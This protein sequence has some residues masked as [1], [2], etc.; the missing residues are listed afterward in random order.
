MGNGRKVRIGWGTK[1][2][3]LM[4]LAAGALALP[5]WAMAQDNMGQGDTGQG[6][7]SQGGQDNGPAARAVRLS[8]VEGQVQLSQGNTVLAERALINTPLFEGTRI[9][10]SDDGRAEVQFED[11][12]VA[13]I[14]PDSSLTLGVLRQQGATS[15]TELDLVSGLGYF[16]LQGDTQS[17]HMRVQFGNSMVTASGF[18]VLRVNVDN[19]PGELAVFSGNAHLDGANSL[20]LDLHGGE[21]VRLSGTDP[22]NYA[23]AETIEPDSWDAWNSDRD[24]ALTSEESDRTA[25]TANV[26]NNNNPAWS[27]LDAN[28][29]WYNVPDQGYV[30]SP[31]EAE[32]SSWDPYGCGS[33]EWTPDYGYIWVSCESWGYM[34]YESGMWSYY[35]GFGWGWAPGSGNCWWDGGGWGYNI[36]NAPFQY[37]RPLRPRGGPVMPR[38]PIRPGGRYEPYPVISVNRLHNGNF[39]GSGRVRGAPIVVAGNTVQPLRPLA[40]RQDYGRESYGNLG[41][42]PVTYPVGNTY[43][44]TNPPAR[45]GYIQSPKSGEVGRPSYWPTAR[46]AG[47]MSRTNGVARPPAYYG[48]YSYH[49]PVSSRGYSPR[50][51]APSHGNFGRAPAGRPSGGGGGFQRGGGGG[52][53]PR[54]GGGGGGSHSS[55]GGGSHH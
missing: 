37:Q 45:Y 4:L 10:T 55:G 30:W 43:R 8:D 17:G 15:D 22:G 7:V 51:S 39:G 33:W 31:Y 46:P 41:R 9:T 53:F 49:P 42:A 23:L 44:G 29:N 12:S 5:T 21:S 16:E 32:D 52:G 6:D 38:N 11:G 14:S 40:P 24:Q 47:G 28:G 54:G 26:P 50:P 20:S 36:G 35:D 27:D 48:G 13:R 1:G 18:T 2:F 25:A 19:P 34:P 3:A